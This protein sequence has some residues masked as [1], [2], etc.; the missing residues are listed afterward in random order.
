ME[1][2]V[3]DSARLVRDRRAAALDQFRRNDAVRLRYE[4]VRGRLVVRG[5]MAVPADPR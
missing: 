5:M 2:L 1:L 4:D 3:P